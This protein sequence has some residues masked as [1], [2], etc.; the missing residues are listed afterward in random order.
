MLPD[1]AS[2]HSQERLWRSEFCDEVKLRCPDIES[3]A[4]HTG[5]VLCQSCNVN[6]FCLLGT[7]AE[8]N[9]YERVLEPTEME[10]TFKE[11]KEKILVHQTLSDSR[12]GTMFDMY[13]FCRP[14]PLLFILKRYS[15]T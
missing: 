6:T 3:G 9:K 4:L 12:T 8:I 11:L 15:G 2:V 7:V 1:R 13:D 14:G 10:V 5:Y